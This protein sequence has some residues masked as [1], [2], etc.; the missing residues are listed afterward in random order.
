MAQPEISYDA[1]SDC[2]YLTWVARVPGTGLMPCQ[3]VLLRVDL[4]NRRLL[5]IMLH[6]FSIRAAGDERSRTLPL[7][8]LPTMSP[9]LRELVLH[10]LRMPAV[11]RYLELVEGAGETLNVVLHAD[12]I[13]GERS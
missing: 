5:S 12:R 10:V 13:A 1:P 8:E 3:D 9:D 11:S 6:N 4:A 7:D 2:L